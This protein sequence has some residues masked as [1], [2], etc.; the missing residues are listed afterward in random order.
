MQAITPYMVLCPSTSFFVL[1][2]VT[3]ITGIINFGNLYQGEIALTG[4]YS[5]IFSIDWRNIFVSLQIFRPIDIW[6]ANVLIVVIHYGLRV[7][8]SGS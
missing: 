6:I 2:L 8:S 3:L 5:M 4:G 7:F 1:S